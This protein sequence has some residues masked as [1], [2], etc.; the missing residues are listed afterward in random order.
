LAWERDVTRRS[1]CIIDEF[2]K[3]T[4]AADG[5]GLLCAT[6]REFSGRRAAPKVIACTHFSEVLE[7]SYLRRSVAGTS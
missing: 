3:G 1:L 2:G 7:A 4:L 5:I 6:L